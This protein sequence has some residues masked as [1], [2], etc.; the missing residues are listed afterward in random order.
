MSTRPGPFPLPLWYPVYNEA[1]VRPSDSTAA[2]PQLVAE[3]FRRSRRRQ[4]QPSARAVTDQGE[5]LAPPGSAARPSSPMATRGVLAGKDHRQGIEEGSS[6][7]PFLE[8]AIDLRRGQ[9]QTVRARGC[10]VDA[11]PGPV[12]CASGAHR[13]SASRRSRRRRERSRRPNRW[14]RK[15]EGSPGG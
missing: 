5:A 15:R 9:G 11:K 12:G 2:P 13:L 1:T 4:E 10:A 7:T 3:P 6:A 14:R 8:P